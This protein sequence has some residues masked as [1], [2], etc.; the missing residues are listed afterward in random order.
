MLGELGGDMTELWLTGHKHVN[1]ACNYWHQNP[2][3]AGQEMGEAAGATRNPEL[4]EFQ[5]ASEGQ[6]AA[7]DDQQLLGRGQ[8]GQEA[9]GTHRIG[10]G[11][12]DVPIKAA[13]WTILSWNKRAVEDPDKGEQANR[14]NYERHIG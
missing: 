11:M 4:R 9:G 14:D 12:F 2:S 7:A 3:G 13:A 1:Q 6:H 5:H 10:K 8:K